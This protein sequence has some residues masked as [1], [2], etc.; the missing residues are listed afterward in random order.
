M[1]KNLEDNKLRE[2]LVLISKRTNSIGLNQGLSGNLSVRINDGILITPS[3][4]PYE[5]MRPKDLVALDLLGNPLIEGQLKPSSE[6]Q[7]HLDLM[8]TRAEVGAVIHCHSLHATALACQEKC[9][10]SFHYM[11]AVAGGNDIRC[12]T[13]ATFGTKEFSGF[14][15]EALEGR[16]ACL[17]AHHG[18]MALG[19]NLKIAFQIAVEVETLSNMY[20]KASLLGDPPVLTSEQMIEVHNQFKSMNYGKKAI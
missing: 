7:L 12:A 17:L 4:V 10:P 1:T 5:E 2:E 18:Q 8:R 6:W 9:I 13:Y 19:E 15:L 16:L 20:L 3:S 14:A 11:T